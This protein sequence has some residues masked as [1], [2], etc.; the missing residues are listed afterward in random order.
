[1]Y[2]EECWMSQAE[3]SESIFW[4]NVGTHF[5]VFFMS[6]YSRLEQLLNPSLGYQFYVHPSSLLE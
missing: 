6:P 1:M 4:H 2:Q 3:K 5:V